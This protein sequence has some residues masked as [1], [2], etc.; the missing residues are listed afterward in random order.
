MRN[1]TIFGPHCSAEVYVH[2]N[3][4]IDKISISS[5]S[6]NST[7]EIPGEWAA[8]NPSPDETTLISEVSQSLNGAEV[9]IIK[10]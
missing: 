10:I 9:T 4:L 1:M 6:S 2:H 8:R 3:G 7:I 5:T